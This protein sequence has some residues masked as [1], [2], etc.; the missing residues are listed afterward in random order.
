MDA[1]T[2]FTC[3]I[4]SPVLPSE[5]CW[6]WYLHNFKIRRVV[7]GSMGNW[8]SWAYEEGDE[9]KKFRNALSKQFN[10]ELRRVERS[11]KESA[12]EYCPVVPLIWI[13]ALVRSYQNI[14]Y[15]K[16]EMKKNQRN[17]ALEVCQ[18]LSHCIGRNSLC[19]STD[20]NSKIKCGRECGDV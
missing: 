16:A 6:Y 17:A 5:R 14:S 1:I 4:H 7:R 12:N 18:G 2:L 3:L 9:E 20:T 10:A 19:I 11:E 15:R 8:A 13:S